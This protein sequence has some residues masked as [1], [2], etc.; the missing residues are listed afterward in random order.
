MNVKNK[1][2]IRRLSFRQ[3]CTA[4]SRNMIAIFAIA[5]TTLLFT[6]LFTIALSINEGFQQSNFRQVGG[7]SHGGFKYLT[8]EQFEEIKDDPLIQE[9]GVRRFVGMPHDIL[10]HKTH[11]EVSYS[12]DLQAHWMYCDP[13][14]GTLPK[15]GTNE[16]ATDTRV[17]ELLGIEPS[18]GAEFTMTFFVDGHE[19]T[20]TFTL[21]GWWEYDKASIASHVLIPLSRAEAIYDEVGLIPGQAADGMTG[22]WNLDVM[23]KN[24]LHIAENMAQVLADHGYQ[25]KGRDAGDNYISTGVNWGYSGSQ[26]S[27]SFDP[28]TAAAIAA[29]LILIIFTGYLIIYNVFQISVANDIRFYGLLKTIGTTPRQLRRIIRHQAVF[30]ALP[31]IPLGL[32]GGWLVGG[33]LTPVVTARLNGVVSMVSTQPMIFILSALFALLTVLISC[34]RPGKMAAKVS[35]IEAV[36]YTEGNNLKQ[37]MRKS[38]KKLSLVSMAMA[39]L[40][41][42]RKKTIV[43]VL[44]LSLAVVL[45]TLTATFTK[46]FDMDKYLSQFVVSDFIVADASYFQT[47]SSFSADTALSEKSIEEIQSQGSVT[48]GGKIYGLTTPVNEFVTE[49]YYR[50]RQGEWMTQ[51]ELDSNVAWMEKTKD[52]HIIDDAQLYGMETFALD[53]LKVMEGDLSKL[54]EPNSR[55]IAAVYSEDDYGNLQPDS[56]WAKVGDTVTLRH[57]KEYEYY[58][59][60]TGEVYPDDVDLDSVSSWGERAREYQDI[61]YT[62]AA[63]VLIP[64]P[65]SYRYSGHDEFVLNATTFMEDTSADSVLLYAFNTS[66]E[67]TEKMNSFLQDYTDTQE[68]HL[69]YE[70]KSMKAGEFESFRSMFLLLGGA[71][72]LI[73]G[74]VGI[75]NFFNAVFTGIMARK[76]EF[77]MLQSVGMTGKQLKTMLMYEGLFYAL[78]AITLSLILT[79]VLS[80]LASNALESIF[81]FFTY[82][83][84][85]TPVLLLLPVFVLLGLLVPLGIYMTAA[86]STIVER[87][88]ET[89]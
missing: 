26:L 16:A 68:P 41:R 85:I 37:K 30:L 2:C 20:Q 31:G 7:F 19:T 18:L 88:R 52:G 45:L 3:F 57:V 23:F 60:D 33:V 56:H 63:L 50:Q 73:I 22:T 4:K 72:S 59:P 15:E 25:N 67:D 69:D 76:R 13:I 86:K 64:Y 21:C 54:Y 12:D 14:K 84:T 61:D 62:V 32:L 29:M 39:N 51:E 82:H 27:D 78:G 34:R 55:Y 77:A 70:S 17:L 10:F 40:G 28:G 24:S 49:D 35:P 9:W 58:N 46:G 38:S 81:W 66:K 53:Q 75:L 43:T 1:H 44:S 65:I 79:L 89:E 87:L 36:R 71:L 47:F 80:P 83:F 48:E 8:Q 74:L 11:V 5:L 42:S 6:A